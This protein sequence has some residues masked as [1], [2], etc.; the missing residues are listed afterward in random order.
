MRM[1]EGWPPNPG[2]AVHV[3]HP[4]TTMI[5]LGLYAPDER[6]VWAS[7]FRAFQNLYIDGAYCGRIP[8]CGYFTLIRPY[9]DTLDVLCE[10]WARV[11][12][13]GNYIHEYP[14]LKMTKA[15]GNGAELFWPPN[16]NR[17]RRKRTSPLIAKS[18]HQAVS[19][20]AGTRHTTVAPN[21]ADSKAF[22]IQAP[23]ARPYGGFIQQTPLHGCFKPSS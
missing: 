23:M 8:V 2:G 7:H 13:L 16:F 9:P 6:Y 19:V 17:P 20:R 18:C 15:L 5:A 3:A 12:L 14:G 21:M 22:L 11:S 10:G 4:V 1:D